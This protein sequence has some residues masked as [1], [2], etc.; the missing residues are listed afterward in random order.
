MAAPLS[1][2]LAKGKEE[3]LKVFKIIFLLLFLL[4]SSGVAFAQDADVNSVK[5]FFRGYVEMGENFDVS[6]AD[7]YLNSAII[8]NLR[9]YP[10][11]SEKSMQLNGAQWK[12]LIIKVMPLAK[13]RGDKSTFSHIII[14]I[15][16]K[17]AKIKANRYSNL[18]CYTDIGYFMIIE[19]QPDGKY[20]IIEE[21][22]ESQPNSDC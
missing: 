1:L 6:S 20:K 15:D 11:G 10:D 22:M 19:L 17:Q 9:R 7:L 8:R 21:Y 18:K 5:E 4:I 13:T 2:T 3:K 14:S 12:E 16:G